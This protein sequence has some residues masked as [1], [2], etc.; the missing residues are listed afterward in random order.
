MKYVIMI[1]SFAILS[2]CI[3]DAREKVASEVGQTY[4][5]ECINGVEYWKQSR[6]YGGYMAPRINP[7]TLTFVRCGEK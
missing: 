1:A 5:V 3:P 7:E 2:A 4:T 6:G